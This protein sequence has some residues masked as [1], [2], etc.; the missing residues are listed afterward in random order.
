MQ[1]ILDGGSSYGYGVSN[2]PGSG[3]SIVD[4]AAAVERRLASGQQHLQASSLTSSTV[5]TGATVAL[6]HL[7]FEHG[8]ASPR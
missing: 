3:T 6:G 8:S 1:W 7:Q 2:L 4:L 5:G